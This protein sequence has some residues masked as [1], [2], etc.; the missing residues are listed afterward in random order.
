MSSEQ[1]TAPPTS[2]V[3]ATPD[4]AN[5]LRGFH[6]RRLIG[7]PLTWIVIAIFV[8][9]AGVAAA[10]YLGA[11]IGAGA[12]VAMLLVSLLLVFAIAD[13]KAEDA[14]FETYAAQRGLALSGKS[15]LP[16]AT[17]LLRKGDARYAERLMAGALADG[18]GGVLALYTYEDET[19]DSEGNRETN[20]YRYTLGL[21]EVPESI[22]HLPELFCQRKSG[23]RSLE[24]LE[25]AFRRSKQRVKLE[26]EAL[27]ERYEIFSSP[28]QDQVWLRRFFSPT[29][30]VWL[31]EEA[32]KKFAFELVGGTLCCYVS[33]HKKSAAELDTIRDATVA[34]AR[35]LREEAEQ[36]S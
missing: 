25:D 20:Y 12:A 4:D 23:L 36:S 8:L 10:I 33:G 35:R 24:K 1:A 19:T 7:K 13:S 27:E 16:A 34:V 21:I 9:V 26:S 31:G 15:P 5:D 30:I 18:T 32:P 22:A 29:F 6:F 14:F 3:E 2:P 17:P 28:E 11:A